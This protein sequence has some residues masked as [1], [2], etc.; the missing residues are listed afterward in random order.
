MKPT[1]SPHLL[2][3]LIWTLLSIGSLQAQNTSKC[4]ISDHYGLIFNAFRYVDGKRSIVLTNV[5][6]VP[7]NHCLA[8]LVNANQMYL[9]YFLKNC[10]HL[11]YK[12][13]QKVV[14]DSTKLQKAFINQLNKDVEF[15]QLLNTFA[16]RFLN[17]SLPP[18]D[19]FSMDKVLDVAVK[20]F[21]IN[22]IT[23][24]GYYSGKVCVGINGIKSTQ[25]ERSLQLEAFCFAAVFEA[26]QSPEFNLQ[27][28]F[29]K[30]I[31]ELYKVQ[32]GVDE[33]ERLLRAQGGMFFLMRNNAQLKA[34]LLHE[35]ELRKG[36]LPFVIKG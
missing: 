31:K 27:A 2:T 19:S 1:F 20:F 25:K 10:S 7:E 24:E 21:N 26:Y 16:A 32:L 9:D 4:A 5:D 30:A 3:A 13:L 36:Y 8:P 18:T 28:E 33:K 22:K 14:D 23:P 35:Y 6:S 29:V 17:P 34:A 15:N 12:A 11:D